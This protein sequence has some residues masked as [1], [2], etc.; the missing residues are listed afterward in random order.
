MKVWYISAYDQ[1]SGQSPRTHEFAIELVKR[2]HEVTFYTNSYCHFT[3]RERLDAGES[4]REEY[5]DGVRVVWL[6]VPS[7][8]GN[9]IGRG[10]NMVWNYF[11]AI[12]VSRFLDDV[13]DVVIGPTVPLLTGYAAARVARRYGV[14]FILEIRDVWPI[15]LVYNGGLMFQGPLYL[16][17]RALEKW[18]Y[19][20]SALI[21]STLPFVH[22]HVRSSGADPSKI[23]WIPNGVSLSS[24]ELPEV[25]APRLDGK[26][27]VMYVGGFGLDHDV[28]VI[29]RAARL[30][31]DAG[32][33][34]FY[35]KI[36]G[37][38]V[39]KPE[40]V[41]MANLYGLNNLEFGDPVPKARLGSV[42]HEADVLVA[43][44]TDTEAL[45]FGLNLNK[46]CTYFASGKPVVFAGNSPNNPVA[47]SGA[48]F[49][50]R[51]EDELQL[52]SAL[53]ALAA[54][55]PSERECIGFLGRLYVEN[56]LSMTVL[57]AKMEA[58][59]IRATGLMAVKNRKSSLI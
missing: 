51:A 56:N 42:Q 33:N 29:I 34:R 46:L 15:A 44:I 5:V 25:T 1:P 37:S 54:M 18:L 24:F 50:V 40:C 39:R 8:K 12:S 23:E 7:F 22:E 9:G 48:G 2:G 17:F 47:D 35:F 30:L 28:P 57:G 53:R 27:L 32:D 19:K 14:P 31:Q 21:C 49:S 4:W 13:P 36:I 26:I 45:R 52:V 11:R 41:E 38:G 20:N 43:A 16:V 3:G 55:S 58:L 10:I 59:L 6:K